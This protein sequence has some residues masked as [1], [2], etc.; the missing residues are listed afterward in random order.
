MTAPEVGQLVEVRLAQ[1]RQ[2]DNVRVTEEDE[3]LKE[4]A[5]SIKAQGILEPVLVA[6]DGDGKFSLVAGYRRCAAA[7]KAGLVVVPAIVTLSAKTGHSQ[8]DVR[9]QQLIENAQRK[10]LTPLEEARAFKA[11]VDSGVTQ[12]ELAKLIGKSQ[13]YVANRVRLLGLPESV[14][15]LLESGKLPASAAQQ[16]LKLPEEA[17]TEIKRV[18]RQVEQDV[19][20]DGA[21]DPRMLR[22]AVSSAQTSYEQRAKKNKVLETTKFPV[23][24][25]KN[26]ESGQPCGAKGHV[27]G[28]YD[29]ET[30]RCRFGH[31]WSAKTGKLQRDECAQRREEPP[32]EPTLPLVDSTIKEHPGAEKIAERIFDQVDEIVGLGLRWQDGDRAWIDLDVRAPKLRGARIPSF[33]IGRWANKN[34]LTISGIED[35]AQRTDEGRKRA[36]VLRAALEAWLATF[37][38]PGRKPGKKGGA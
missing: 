35:Y 30:L 10:D 5:E 29:L 23:C 2:D 31:R 20:R 28:S 19:Q 4:L 11:I 17:A 33:D 25:G 22:Y 14:V 9:V 3:Q 12:S 37:G 1:L 34:W 15:P 27:A 6:A 8:N 24:P 13:P 36:A 7:K 26:K 16:I 38:K 32:P 18:V 21:Y